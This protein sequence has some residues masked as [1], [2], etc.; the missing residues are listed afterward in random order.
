M[1]AVTRAEHIET[2]T[3]KLPH[4][5]AQSAMASALAWML[6]WLWMDLAGNAST[7]SDWAQTAYGGVLCLPGSDGG[8]LSRTAVFALGWLVM[9][10]A[11]M[12]PAALPGLISRLSPSTEVRPGW[13]SVIVAVTAYLSVWL[14]VGMLMHGGWSLISVLAAQSSLLAFND[15][16]I[17]VLTLAIAGGYQL[18]E[19]KARALRAC[20]ACAVKSQVSREEPGD[21]N[22]LQIGLLAGWQCVRCGWALM[23]LM[24]VFWPGSLPWMMVVGVIMLIDRWAFSRQLCRTA[25]GVAL[26]FAAVALTLA[27]LGPAL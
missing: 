12:G 24:F 11:M 15:W 13:K 20:Q 18:S 23:L 22:A 25:I 8:A 1:T 17:G 26:V 9:I 21:I 16:L 6:L 3:A 27:Q 19:T 5:T 10:V 14:G 7:T 2:L 4:G